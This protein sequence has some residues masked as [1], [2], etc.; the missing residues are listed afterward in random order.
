MSNTPIKVCVRESNEKANKLRR[1]GYVPAVIYGEDLDKPIS[2]KITN[3]NILELLSKNLK[4][5]II[6]LNVNDKIEH[7]IIKEIQTY[8]GTNKVIHLDFQEINKNEVIKM[9]VP[10]EFLN[11]EL[12][13]SKNLTLETF[14]DEIEIQGKFSDIPKEIKI[15]VS[16]LNYDDQIFA[17]DI[18]LPEN[19]KLLAA[20]N[21]VIAIV[22]STISNEPDEEASEA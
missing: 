2:I 11:V 1:S 19:A 7:C 14:M 9:K 12:L 16:S 3:K 6:N 20:D 8:P 13:G 22:A 15:D 10:V 4:T 21:A 17:K 18:D 5:S